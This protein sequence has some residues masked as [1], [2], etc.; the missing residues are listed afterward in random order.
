MPPPQRSPTSSVRDMH[1][2]GAVVCAPMRDVS[3][4]SPSQG[5]TAGGVVSNVPDL[6]NFAQALAT[7]SLLSKKSRTDQ[8]DAVVDGESWQRYGLGVQLL[9]P[10]RGSSGAIPGYS[11]ALF[12]DPAS[13]LTIVVALNNSTPGPAFAQSLAQRLA[14][15]VSK[16]PA[17]QKGAK[18]VASLPWSEQQTVDAM[19]KAAPC[20]KKK[21]G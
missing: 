11:S 6:K 21:A 18:V 17:K 19:T 16:V 14:S 13:G 1:G 20:P 7:G 2:A 9:G 5:W 12:A 4:L 15:V 8:L 3:R 10:L